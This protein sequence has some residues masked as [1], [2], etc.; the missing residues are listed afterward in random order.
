M[1]LRANHSIVVGR[2]RSVERREI[3]QMHD[4]LGSLDVTQEIVTETGSVA[5]ALDQTRNVRKNHPSIARQLGDAELRL[6]GGERISADLGRRPTGRVQQ[7]RLTRVGQP[8]E[9]DIGD[10][11]QFK[12]QRALHRIA[13]RSAFR[14]RLMRRS[15]ESIV[16]QP[17]L[18]ALGDHD[19]LTFIKNVRHE[20]AGFQ[21]A[22]HGSQ[23]HADKQIR[24]VATVTLLARALFARNGE[25]MRP[26]LK[27]NQ[28]VEMRIAHQDHMSAATAVASIGTTLLDG[29][30]AAE[31]NDA[32]AAF[33]AENMDDGFV[34]EHAR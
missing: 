10:Q 4:R 6:A 16:A 30:L 29:L 21:V 3:D 13:T 11:L 5:C 27:L 34:N 24:A 7:R 1:K 20:I 23:R 14:G 19:L 2:L 17:A 26:M 9:S 33:A 18:P 32:V 12:P 28:R 25:A 8:D 15:L 22:D 31:R